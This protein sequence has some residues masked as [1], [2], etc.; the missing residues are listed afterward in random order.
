MKRSLLVTA[1]LL[2]FTSAAFASKEKPVIGLSLDTLKEERWQ[3][4]RDSITAKAE[5][6]G[7]TVITQ[8]AN[9]DDTRQTSDIKALI[10]RGVDVLVIVAHNGSGLSRAVKEANDA[11][12]PVI[13]YDRLIMNADIALY[14]TFDNIKVGELQ[15]Q[16]LLDRAPKDH[17][18][19]IV[20][21]NGAPTDNNAK[22]FKQGQDNVFQPLIKS[23][24]VNILFEDWCADWKPEN[25]KKVTNAALAKF[26]HDF[27][28]LLATT[29]HLAAGGIQALTE[30]GLSG[31]IIV[32]GQDADLSACQRIVRGTQA[33]TIYKPLKILAD[34]AAEVAVSIAKGG[35]VPR[36]HTTD[37]GLKQVPSV[38][39]DIVVVTKDNMAATV[40]ADGFHKAEELK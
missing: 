25:A 18:L 20:R 21:L 40:I 29:D 39:K 4:D 5:S 11:K 3:K 28:A 6:L 24:K 7:A 27:D 38:F 14:V 30:E 8:S 10:T 19:R 22:L 33:M 34:Y 26:G 31:K 2:A 1:L 13:A 36:E 16:F 15:A 17:P 32:T 9:G 12:I 37:N 23:G 35:A